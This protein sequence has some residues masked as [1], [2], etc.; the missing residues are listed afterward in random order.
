MDAYLPDILQ[1]AGRSPRELGA[2]HVHAEPVVRGPGGEAVAVVWLQAAFVTVPEGSRLDVIDVDTQEVVASTALPS[3]DNGRAVRWTL[4]LQVRPEA[5]ALLFRPEAPV[6]ENTERVRAPWKLFDTVE[7]VKE[8]ELQ[9]ASAPPGLSRLVARGVG[10]AV[11]GPLGA[12]AASAIVGNDSAS[13]GGS[14]GIKLKVHSARELPP[15]FIAPVLAAETSPSAQ[16]DVLTVWEMGQEVDTERLRAMPRAGAQEAPRCS[17]CGAVTPPRAEFCPECL[18]A[19]APP[20]VPVQAEPLPTE[21]PPA[22]ARVMPEGATPCPLHAGH[23]IVGTCTR[24]GAF[25]CDE[26]REQVARLNEGLCPACDARSEHKDPVAAANALH[27]TT[28]NWQLVGWAAALTVG[29]VA[30]VAEGRETLLTVA[31]S[32]V[33]FVVLLP[34]LACAVLVRTMRW[35]WLLGG[36]AVLHFVYCFITMVMSGSCLVP[37]G[38]LIL[39]LQAGM[40]ALKLSQLR[41]AKAEAA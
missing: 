19:L 36:S 25:Y 2:V 7:Q 39:S 24:C 33:T 41:E 37:A 16:A 11:A 3:L 28:G 5:S 18:S 4:P 14:S 34:Q 40:A 32:A 1:A 29:I 8:S 31:A 15:G 20:S 13:L 21:A 35:S 38:M 9:G 17:Q 26:C 10:L 6:A 23:P 22:E 27:R 12:L 30:F